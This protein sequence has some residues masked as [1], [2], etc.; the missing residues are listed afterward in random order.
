MR[1]RA[2]GQLLARVA[3]LPQLCQTQ[4]IG[5]ECEA[6][7]H[8]GIAHQRIRLKGIQLVGQIRLSRGEQC[9]AGERPSHLGHE[10]KRGRRGIEASML[11]YHGDTR[12]LSQSAP[13]FDDSRRALHVG[14]RTHDAKQ[15]LDRAAILH[16][17]QRH[18]LAARRMADG[19][20]AE[21]PAAHVLWIAQEML[22]VRPPNAGIGD[23]VVE[24]ISQFFF[25]S[26]RQLFER[27]GV[28]IH[29]AVLVAIIRGVLDRE[30]DQ[31]PQSLAGQALAALGRPLGR[32][33]QRTVRETKRIASNNDI[34][35]LAVSHEAQWAPQ[36]GESG[37]RDQCLVFRSDRG[38]RACILQ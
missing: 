3:D 21:E 14:P 9:Q 19:V 15:Q 16:D 20:V 27:A 8:A 26:A 30:A 17:Q 7:E 36:P 22:D 23:Y 38:R 2:V 37:N 35:H 28:E 5:V 4:L 13:A 32:M 29:S 10:G 12:R 33:R 6:F 31:P 34:A 25:V 24:S 11:G 1:P 18:P